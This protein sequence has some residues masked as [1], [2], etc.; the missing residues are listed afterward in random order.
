MFISHLILDNL[1]FNSLPAGDALWL[2]RTMNYGPCCL[3]ASGGSPI[4]VHILF[5]HPC[6]VTTTFFGDWVDVDLIFGYSE[7]LNTLRP[8]KNSCHFADGTFKSIFLNEDIWISI[9][10]SLTGKL[11]PKGQINNIPALIQIMAWGRPGDKPLSEP[12][13]II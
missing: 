8:R 2:S 10:I 12:M 13:I 1:L 5:E 3:T 7:C 6:Q 11:V 9:N 4:L